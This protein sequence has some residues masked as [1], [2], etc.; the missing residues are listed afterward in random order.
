MDAEGAA[1]LVRLC[2]LRRRHS[3]RGNL[4]AGRPPGDDGN[5]AGLSA[6]AATGDSDRRDSHGPAL[7]A[8]LVGCLIVTQLV[9]QVGPELGVTPVKLLLTRCS[10]GGPKWT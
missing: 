8:G 5:R 4:A 6:P 3:R 1:A 9:T 10:G 2:S 7:R